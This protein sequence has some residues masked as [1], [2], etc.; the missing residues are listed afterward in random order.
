GALRG[1]DQSMGVA[2]G[3]IGSVPL[4]S[5][6]PLMLLS[7]AP[8]C[9]AGR[10]TARTGPFS[11]AAKTP[12][13]GASVQ[14]WRLVQGQNATLAPARTWKAVSIPSKPEIPAAVTHRG[15]T[16]LLRWHGMVPL[17]SPCSA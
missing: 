12:G 4:L 7:I 13:P 10:N 16:F 2:A 5:S 15:T 6:S 17:N 11:C 9:P 1:Y 14:A 3:E 8:C